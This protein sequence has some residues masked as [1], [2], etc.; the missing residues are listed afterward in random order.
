MEPRFNAKDFFWFVAVPAIAVL[1]YFFALPVILELPARG[2]FSR[3]SYQISNS[4]SNLAAGTNHTVILMT[5]DTV[6][7]IGDNTYG[8]CDVSGWHDLTALAAGSRHTVGLNADGTVVAVGDNTY[9][10]CDVAEWRDI[11]A[12]AAGYNYTIGLKSDGSFVAT[13]DNTYGQCEVAG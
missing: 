7:A 3:G 2:L 4:M 1:F 10:Q 8:Q 13:G 12:I 11:I 5:D 9:G 6:K